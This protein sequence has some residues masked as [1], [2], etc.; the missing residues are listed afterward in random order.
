MV[1]MDG[2]LA[3][4]GILAAVLSGTAAGETYHLG[5][6]GEWENV[7]GTPEGEYLLA[8]SKIK[9]QIMSGSHQEV[10][11]A[12]EQLKTDFPELAG[13]SID[14]FIAAEKLYAGGALGKAAARYKQFM[15]A[16]PDSVLYS[17]SLE[18]LYSIGTAFLQGQKRTYI[19]V[20][21]L[22]AFDDGVDI[23]WDIAE[24][25]GNS[26]IALQALTT[27]A[28]NQERREK[29]FDAYQTWA[30]IHTRWPTGTMGQESLMRM[31]QE[32]HASYTGP[33]FDA[34]ALGSARSY[35]E[36]FIARYPAVAEQMNMGEELALIKE[37]LA[38]KQYETGFYYERT[39]K[40]D[41][42]KMYY[43]KVLAEWPNSKAAVMAA[44]R[45]HAEAP[46]AVNRT[47]KRKLFDIAN[48]FL[49]SWFGIEKLHD[50]WMEAKTQREQSQQ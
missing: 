43:D 7:A 9:Q 2:F 46:P 42:A 6:G 1:K 23:M 29:Y 14:G 18:R 41:V 22:P 20:L 25:A 31:A 8:V 38:Y 48:V 35:Y 30:E 27:L 28:E 39:G 16:Y 50:K 40:T 26:P 3:V 47:R 49:D 24:R 36:D 33:Q 17:V 5:A 44:N 19:K 32:L 4:L 15:N 37:Q 12:L 21:R 13:A 34:G 45:L 11:Q 10:L